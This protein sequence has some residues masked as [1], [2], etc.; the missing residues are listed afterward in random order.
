MLRKNFGSP[1]NVQLN[2]FIQPVLEKLQKEMVFVVI[3]IA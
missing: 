2:A 1:A 3:V